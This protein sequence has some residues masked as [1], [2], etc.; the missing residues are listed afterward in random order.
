VQPHPLR[1]RKN[2]RCAG[3]NEV[4]IKLSVRVIDFKPALA[5]SVLLNART[6][7]LVS[8]ISCSVLIT[9]VYF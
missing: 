9:F 7:L 1:T 5:N 6:V 3:K 4:A 8:E 2:L